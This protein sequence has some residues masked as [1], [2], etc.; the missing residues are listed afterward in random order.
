MKAY[1]FNSVFLIS[2]FLISFFFFSSFVKLLEDFGD[3]RR[4]FGHLFFDRFNLLFHFTLI[5]SDNL[6]LAGN[7][8]FQIFE[9]LG[10]A[11][12]DCS[13]CCI[14]WRVSTF[15]FS[16]EHNNAVIS[17]V[18]AEELLY[19][20]VLFDESNLVGIHSQSSCLLKLFV[21]SR[22]FRDQKVVKGNWHEVDHRGK[23]YPDCCGEHSA[24]G[25]GFAS[26]AC[27]HWIFDVSDGAPEHVEMIRG[28][29]ADISIWIP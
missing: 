14:Q 10:K 1:F 6:I 9:L 19:H 27:E 24:I 5:G 2:F 29:Y 11:L 3:V 26:V 8:G 23:G 21:D 20:Q 18:S 4:D 16:L 22:N 28:K 25:T 13:G 17:F 15:Q 12:L 7:V